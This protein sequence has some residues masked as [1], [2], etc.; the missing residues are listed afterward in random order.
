MKKSTGS[1]EKE[2]QQLLQ[3]ETRLTHLLEALR[4]A[5]SDIPP[6]A[7]N[8]K[9]FSSLKGALHL[10]ADGQIIHQFGDQRQNGKL[11]WQGMVIK[12]GA[13]TDVHAIY[14][15]RVAFADWLRNFGWLIIIDHG[16]G[17]MSLYGHNEA[18]YKDVGEWVEQN[19]VI[20]T[21]GSSGGQQQS[22]LYFEIRQNGKPRN[23]RLWLGKR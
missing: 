2:L 15:G 3:D 22:G 20:A 18:L 14:N 13:G 1:K 10:P 7:G 23:P 8:L 11:Q 12:A 6:D 17:Y 5:L 16:D 4:R 19:E 21:T 9:A